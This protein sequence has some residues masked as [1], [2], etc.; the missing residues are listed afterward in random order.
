MFAMDLDCYSSWAV[1]FYL[2][3]RNAVDLISFMLQ[4]HPGYRRGSS[5]LA[6]PL[7]T[8]DLNLNLKFSQILVKCHSHAKNK[9]VSPT[10]TAS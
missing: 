8:A 10:F 1:E 7:L 4:F 2:H 6:S 5:R 3:S 9:I